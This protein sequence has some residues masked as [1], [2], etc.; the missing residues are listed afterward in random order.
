MADSKIGK[1]CQITVDGNRILGIGTWTWSGMSVATLEDTEFLD[2][3][4]KF[5]VG[6]INSGTIEF[7]GQHKL[8]DTTGQDVVSAAFQAGTKITDIKLYADGNSYYTPNSTTAPGGGLPAETMVSWVHITGSS[9]S[10]DKN[11]LVTISYTAQ[12]SGALRLI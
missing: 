11:G 4:Q 8:D 9:I 6:L 3:H 5:E 1:D 10:A 12:I 7:N 2:N